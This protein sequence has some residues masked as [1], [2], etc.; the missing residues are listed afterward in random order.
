M[1]IQATYAAAAEAG[2]GRKYPYH[3]QIMFNTDQQADVCVEYLVGVGSEEDRHSAGEH[4]IRRTG[5]VRHQGTAAEEIRSHADQ[6]TGIPD[7]GARPVDLRFQLA[8][9]R[10]GWA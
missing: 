5:Y 4:G 10:R 2:D 1:T 9:G 8:K 3:Y 7:L 6:R